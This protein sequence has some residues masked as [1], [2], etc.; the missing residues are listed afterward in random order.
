MM[1]ASLK[2]LKNPGFLLGL[3]L[4]LLALIIL[5]QRPEFSAVDALMEL[6]IF[7]F[8]FS[9][10]AWL[11]TRHAKPLVVAAYP[12]G[13]EMI[14]LVAYVLAVSIYLVFGPQWVDSWLPHQW[15]TSD[16]ARFFVSLSR[17]LIVFVLLPFFLF[18]PLCGYR[19]SDFGWQKAGVR[20]LWRSHLP[21]VVIV[22]AAILAFQFF[23]GG[24]AAP[25]RAGKLTTHQLVVGL[26]LCFVWL[27]IEAGLVEE[28]FFRALIQS[29]LSAWFR[30][31][32][33]GV[34]LMALI[35]GLAHA[36]GFIFRHAGT[37]EGLGANPS[38]VD[39]I[40]YS[41]VILSVSGVFPGII[42]ARTKNIFVVIVIHAATD[43]LPNLPGFV[44][45]W[46]L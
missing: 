25:I 36:P 32:I 17:K 2:L 9:L 35:F 16:R 18:G 27:A 7:G 10:L 23:L 34:A 45:T 28:F 5:S 11:T 22:S 43:L 26:P 21:V 12:T 29:R 39:A 38:A 30:S 1:K 40:A 42:W 13:G 14:A 24:G 46:G 31:E 41:I 3:G 15:V 19:L 33:T 20:E 4:Y 37:V 6:L 44:K 8:G